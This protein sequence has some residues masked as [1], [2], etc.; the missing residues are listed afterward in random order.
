MLWGVVAYGLATA[1]F[2]LSRN[3]HLSLALS[4]ALAWAT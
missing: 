1:A 3:F 2:G 4:P